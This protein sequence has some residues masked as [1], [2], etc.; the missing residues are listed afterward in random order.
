MPQWIDQEHPF[1]K[2]Q[3]EAQRPLRHVK[4]GRSWFDEKACRQ[5]DGQQHKQQMV[6]T[7]QHKCMEMAMARR[8]SIVE[9]WGQ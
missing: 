9:S 4:R 2:S 6:E 8:T 7:D 5:S 1:A 3:A